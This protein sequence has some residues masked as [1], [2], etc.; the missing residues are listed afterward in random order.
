M[1][2]IAVLCCICIVYGSFRVLQFVW[3]S[4]RRLTAGLLPRNMLQEYG[5][6][7]WAVITGASDGI[8]EQ[9]AKE[10]ARRGFNICLVS[11]TRSKLERVESDIHR[12]H[13]KSHTKVVV[14]DLSHSASEPELF[15]Y[16]YD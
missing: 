6:N 8:G 7:S 11:R 12:L 9:F 4:G 16:L 13:P 14:I 1:E 15:D 3:V 2:L 5:E 10:L